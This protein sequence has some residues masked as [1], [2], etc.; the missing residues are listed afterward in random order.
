[1]E[2]ESTFPALLMC[3]KAY[4]LHMAMRDI[5][6][7]PGEEVFQHSG[8][9]WF[10]ILLDQLSPTMRDQIIFI[11][12]RAWH[13]R[14]DL[15]FGKGTESVTNSANFVDNYWSTF[16]ACHSMPLEDSKNKRKNPMSGLKCDPNTLEVQMG[17]KPQPSGYIKINVDASFVER[18][19]AASLGVVARDF[20]GKSLDLFMG[21]HWEV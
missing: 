5:W 18:I 21:L 3:P 6:D 10:L 14:T 17:W 11:F 16:G 1:M 4:A 8:S 20:V 7:L 13:L 9:D 2:D 15:I 19:S 12:W